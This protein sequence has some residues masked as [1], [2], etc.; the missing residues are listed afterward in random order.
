MPNA[1]NIEE[2][3]ALYITLSIQ[4][5]FKAEFPPCIVRYPTTTVACAAATLRPLCQVT[6]CR[7]SAPRWTSTWTRACPTPC[8]STR[9][10]PAPAATSFTTTSSC[11]PSTAPRPPPGT[12]AGAGAGRGGGA[13]RGPSP[14]SWTCPWT[15]TAP[16][17]TSPASSS[18]RTCQPRQHIALR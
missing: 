18:S 1:S 4:T 3:A 9:A 15:T 8:P 14:T 12:G 16:G 11:G 6:T 17:T 13:S 2:N 7:C 5:I 10:T